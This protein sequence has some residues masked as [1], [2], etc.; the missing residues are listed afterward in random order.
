MDNMDILFL[1]STHYFC[2]RNR[3]TAE[4]KSFTSRTKLKSKEV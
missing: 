3:T 2:K 1:K 4:P